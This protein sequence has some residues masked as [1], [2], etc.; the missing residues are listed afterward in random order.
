[1]EKSSLPP[2]ISQL[3]K[4][5]SYPHRVDSITLTQTHISYLIFAGD[6]VYKWKKPVNFGFLDFSTLA[7]RRFFCEEEVRLNRRMCG[8]MY[9][10]VVRVTVEN[11]R[12]VLDGPGEGVEFGVKMRRLPQELMM[13]RVI[14]D[15][16]LTRSHLKKIVDK[17]VAFYAGTE[18]MSVASGYGS[19]AAVSKTIHD[20]F[21]ETSPF[22][23]GPALSEE[24]FYNIRQ[25]AELFLAQPGVFQK[26]MTTGRVR[27]CHGDLH[28]ANICLTDDVAI[29]D[30]IEFNSSLRR[31]DI[32]ADVAFLAMDLDF[33]G[34]GEL[35][36]F[37]IDRFIGSSGD[38]GIDELLNFYKCYR[39]YVRG[40]IGL[41]TSADCGVG[42][43]V[44]AAALKVA[45]KYFQLAEEYT[46]RQ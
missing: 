7:R 38:E 33:H 22:I 18:T 12:Y 2:Y 46:F 16:N 26:R 1:M 29:F 34:L 31:T 25:Y 43:E 19:V 28:S 35:S 6:F 24:R 27:D 13:D 39:A 8:K 15:G 14:A 41:L 21:T 32:A 11:N 4:P 17:L 9:R 37:F 42:S 5:E 3:L 20:N 40:K 36:S 45:A 10:G 23:G 30:C 44:A